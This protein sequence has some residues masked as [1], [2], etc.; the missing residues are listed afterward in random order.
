MASA[1]AGAKFEAGVSA[2]TSKATQ[3]ASGATD[4]EVRDTT[5]AGG[6]TAGV[7][8]R[9]RHLGE[10]SVTV[11]EGAATGDEATGGEATATTAMS[12]TSVGATATA[13]RLQAHAPV[14]DRG[15]RR[16]TRRD[17]RPRQS[18]PRHWTRRPRMW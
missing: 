5:A 6:E 17:R 3:A 4:R 9:A 18:R 11:T 2:T 16:R 14:L 8:A 13:A 1:T 10:T 7:T 12:A 15:A